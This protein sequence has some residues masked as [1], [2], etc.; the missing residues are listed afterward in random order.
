MGVI[1]NV[2]P[3]CFGKYKTVQ[4]VLKLHKFVC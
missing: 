1:L 4:A 2:F 3:I